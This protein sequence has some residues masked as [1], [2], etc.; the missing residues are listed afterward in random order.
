MHVQ[1]YAVSGAA[2]EGCC[3]FTS[4]AVL[5]PLPWLWRIC[6]RA[7][8]ASRIGAVIAPLSALLCRSRSCIALVDPLVPIVRVV[9]LLVGGSDHGVG[10]QISGVAAL[11]LLTCLC[12]AVRVGAPVAPGVDTTVSLVWQ[13]I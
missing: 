5:W 9:P 4:H 1:W 7:S 10:D 12:G 13:P 3:V 6:A 8:G 2:V 11:R